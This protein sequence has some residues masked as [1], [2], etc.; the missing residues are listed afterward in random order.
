[1]QALA[2]EPLG[3]NSLF[4]V[5]GKVA[6]VT[7]GSK[8][9]GRMIAQGLVENG[10]TVFV[11]S[12]RAAD[13][14]KAVQEL[15]A[16]GPGKAISLPADVAGEADCKALVEKLSQQTDKLHILINN[17]GTTWGAPFSEYPAAAWDKVMALNVKAVFLL[18]RCC[19]PLLQR[20]A[21]KNDPARVIN[22]GSV[23][24]LRALQTV[25]PNA[26]FAY[27]AS[28]AAVHHLTR[29]LVPTLAP[30]NITCNAIAPGLVP[31]NM[32]KH[33]L[34][35]EQLAEALQAANPLGRVGA[36]RDMAGVIIFLC[37]NAGS[38]VN[39]T[40]IPLDGGSHLLAQPGKL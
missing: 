11:C 14:D 40:V 29:G 24:G 3:A 31:S 5:A 30:L 1:M 10:A 15:N 16:T 33:L 37:S 25:G 34:K 26:A 39:G 27:S 19:L 21:S 9:I 8:G 13:C 6:L 23:D 35:H 18:T 4:G 32:T 17:A 2:Q 12:R 36:P 38:W 7:G 20:G 28:K 22:V